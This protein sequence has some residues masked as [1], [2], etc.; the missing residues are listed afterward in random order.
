MIWVHGDGAEIDQFMINRRWMQRKRG[1]D[2]GGI[3]GAD[4]GTSGCFEEVERHGSLWRSTPG[5]EIDSLGVVWMRWVHKLGGYGGDDCR[6][7]P[8]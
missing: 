4:L 3:E 5:A 2:G 1:L 8:W 6:E 7:L